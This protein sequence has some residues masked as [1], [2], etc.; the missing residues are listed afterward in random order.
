VGLLG[1]GAVAAAFLVGC[2]GYPASMVGDS[3]QRSNLDPPSLLQ[4][5]F[6][7]MQIG[8]FLLARPWIAR[9]TNR[10]RLWLTVSETNRLALP[11][12][13]WHQ[14]ALVLVILASATVAPMPGLVDAP[15]SVLWVLHRVCWLPMVA[16][17]LVGIVRFHRA[18][19]AGAAGA[20]VL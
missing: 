10:R 8:L 2:A 11:I 7:A 4:L 15:S 19:S 5:A 3:G 9:I 1:G 6:S 16:A 13:L 18:R 12:Y 20:A 17:V 14:S